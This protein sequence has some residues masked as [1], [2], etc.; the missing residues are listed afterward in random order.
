MEVFDYEIVCTGVDQMFATMAAKQASG[1]FKAYH[2]KSKA[3]D[4]KWDSITEQF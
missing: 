1:A 3:Q 4:I 2:R